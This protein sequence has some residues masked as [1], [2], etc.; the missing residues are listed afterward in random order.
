MGIFSEIY[1]SLFGK[2]EKQ[3]LAEKPSTFGGDGTS[4]EEAVVVNCASMSMANRI[5]D[6]FISDRHGE[7]G[8]DWSREF[9]MFHNSP[10]EDGPTIRMIG[11]KMS[12]DESHNYYFNVSRP[13]GA[14]MDL[15]N[16]LKDDG[17]I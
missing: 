11:V 3:K 6:D 12:N 2:S 4:P 14:T 1:E 10:M 9:E 17:E 8:D 15:I 5:I 16:M 7:K 13:M